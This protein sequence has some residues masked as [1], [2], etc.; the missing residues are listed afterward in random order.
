MMSLGRRSVIPLV[1]ARR[2]RDDA[3]R[4]LFDGIDPVRHKRAEAEGRIR[5]QHG[6]F[7]TVVK[8]WLDFKAGTVAT[9]IEAHLLCSFGV[10]STGTI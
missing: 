8:A 3:R 1:L 7:P 2:E 9:D 5:E 4:L 10:D 6:M